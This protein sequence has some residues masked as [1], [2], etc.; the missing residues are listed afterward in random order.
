MARTARADVGPLAPYAHGYRELLAGLGYTPNGVVRKLWEL[1]RLSSWMI[2][3]G[4][5]P[6]GLTT[7]RF[8]EFSALCAAGIERPVGAPHPAATGRL[9]ARPGGGPRRDGGGDCHR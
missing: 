1:G 4:L 3:N 5:G 8:G 2:V 9:S 6:D 7:G